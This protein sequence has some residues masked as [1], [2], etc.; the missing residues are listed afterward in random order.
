[1]T[2]DIAKERDQ[3]R[4]VHKITRF[5]YKADDAD[6][7]TAKEY[8][9]LTPFLKGYAHYLQADHE[10]CQFNK[11]AIRNTEFMAGREQAKKEVG[12]GLTR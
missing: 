8:E 5:K 7:I 6:L 11:N 12:C 2:S 3:L 1:M 4:I 10:K 9:L